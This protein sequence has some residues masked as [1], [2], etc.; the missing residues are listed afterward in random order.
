MWEYLLPTYSCPIEDRVGAVFDGG[1]YMCGKQ[2]L[3]QVSRFSHTWHPHIPAGLSIV[4]NL[5]AYLAV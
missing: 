3:L 2:T 1:M 4:R 5:A